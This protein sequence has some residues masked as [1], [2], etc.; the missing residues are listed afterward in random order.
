MALLLTFASGL[1]TAGWTAVTT[2]EGTTFY[3]DLSTVQKTSRTV[4]MWNL[5][6]YTKP[7]PG[8]DGLKRYLSMK[9][10]EE[11][12]CRMRQ[13]Q[14]LYLSTHTGAM[15]GGEVAFLATYKSDWDP[16]P[17]GSVGEAMMK[18]ACKQ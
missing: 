18:T 14:T 12:D 2:V 15:G 5:L 8:I 7:Q 4:K 10:Q 16:I 9:R 6:N 13:V 1:A 17:P 11:Y 3:V